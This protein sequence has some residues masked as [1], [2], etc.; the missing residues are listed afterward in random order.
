MA[1]SAETLRRLKAN[2]REVGFEY[3]LLDRSRVFKKD[4]T[5]LVLECRIIHDSLSTLIMSATLTMADS[6]GVD[7]LNDLIRVA[8][9][10]T[11]QGAAESF[12][13]GTFMIASPGRILEGAKAV[14]ELELYSALQRLNDDKVEERHVVYAHTNIINEV[15]RLVG[16]WPYSIPLSGKLA[17]VDMEWGIG[18]PK[19]EIINYL[20]DMVGYTPLRPHAD[21]AFVT[22]P[23]RLPQER[24]ISIEYGDGADSVVGL[25]FSE[26]IDVFSSPN[27]FVRYTNKGEGSNMRSVYVNSSADSATSTVSRGRRIV[28][29]QEAEAADLETL[30][31]ITK[32]AAAEA[33]QA[34]SYIEFSTAIMPIHGYMDILQLSCAGLSGRF[35]E[36]KW[37]IECAAGTY[38]QHRARKVVKV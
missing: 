15:I 27:V 18:T 3:Y 34:Y 4:I 9:V 12:T 37:E 26:D 32:K 24:G 5:G 8:C 35:E 14:R 23:Y 25:G 19:L 17:A 20:L 1:V 33:A 30:D 28:D 29:C 13:L 36:T 7:W 2:G 11:V 38:M 6:G 22:E 21:G 16:S 10:V 31:I